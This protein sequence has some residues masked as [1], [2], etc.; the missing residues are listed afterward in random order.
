[1]NYLAQVNIP[2]TPALS[3]LY[4]NF[5]ADQPGYWISRLLEY[6]IVIA[7]LIFFA[8]LVSAGF[9]YLTSGGD[10]GKIQAATKEITNAVIGLVLVVS[11]F[12]IKQ[13]LVVLFGI[14]I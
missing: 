8:K 1:M 4:G 13:I 6:S 10:S 14:K 9:S 3:T 7:G 11:V 2:L 5:Y 12:F